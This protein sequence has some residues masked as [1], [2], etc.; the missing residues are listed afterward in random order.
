VI[1]D[2]LRAN[3]SSMYRQRKFR[4]RRRYFRSLRDT[5]AEIDLRID[6]DSWFDGWHTHLDWYGYGAMS[7]RSRQAHLAALAIAFDAC[8]SQLAGFRKPY[9]LWMYVTSSA[10]SMDA[11]CAHSP[12]PNGTEFPLVWSDV[13]WGVPIVSDY[14]QALLPE[15]RMRAGSLTHEGVTDYFV[16]SSSVGI[17]LEP[18]AAD[19]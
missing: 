14:F 1:Q 5:A 15:Q 2:L 7:W 13:D 8:A 19:S 3:P 4:G 12:N 6:E 18:L 16:Y 17:S 10:P 9:Q 11:V